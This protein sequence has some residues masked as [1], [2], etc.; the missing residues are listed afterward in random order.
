MQHV[1]PNSAFCRNW[2]G[3]D[4]RLHHLQSDIG[5]L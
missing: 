5:R 1:L 4:A 3:N 2:D